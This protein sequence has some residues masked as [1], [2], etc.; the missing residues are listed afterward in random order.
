MIKKL[1]LSNFRNYK[2]TEISFNSQNIVFTGRSG[3]GKTNLLEAIFFLSVL[4]SFRTSKTSDI[5]KIGENSFYLGA[6][7]KKEKWNEFIEIKYGEK[8]QR[9][10][11]I[12]NLPVLKASEFINQIR[13]V[14]FSP[15]DVNIVTSNSGLRRRFMDILI[16]VINPLYLNALRDYSVALKNRNALLRALKVD[17]QSMDAYED[18]MAE[19]SFK[20]IIER[21][22]YS[23]ILIQE[24]NQLLSNLS[25][26][27]LFNIHYSAD[28]K[29]ISKEFIKNK[30]YNE[31]NR[32]LKRGF[33][34]FGPQTDEFELFFDNKLMRS[35]SST[36]QCRLISLCLKMAK[37]NILCENNNADMENVLVLV[38]DVTGE[39]D[40]VMRD[41]FFKVISRAGQAFFT[42]TE[43][44]N[45]DFF[46]N[47][48]YYNIIDGSINKIEDS[49]ESN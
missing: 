3:Q 16:S 4:R 26:K 2:K 6:E 24:V 43:K 33:T 44:P 9:K 29:D 27:N 34:G 32:D 13:T 12:D 47:C 25:N 11:T 7:I 28:I 36:G 31:R 37:L 22:K 20:I 10:L 15:E 40:K 17:L 35:F 5:K 41:M 1:V 23:K 46:E 8:R 30:F 21:Q 19:N 38:D 39:L 48:E 49:D 18:I 45:F 42:F 14:I